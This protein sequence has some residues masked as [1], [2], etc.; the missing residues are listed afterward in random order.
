MIG[1][2]CGCVWGSYL[3]GIFDADAFRRWFID[4]LRMRRGLK[5][6]GRVVTVYDLQESFDR[7]ANVV[8][9]RLDMKQIYQLLKL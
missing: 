9:Q 7:L 3:H 6:V 1:V 8:R 5:A 4:R 2:G